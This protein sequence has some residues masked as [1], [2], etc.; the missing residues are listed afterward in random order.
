MIA[1][2]ISSESHENAKKFRVGKRSNL[3]VWL[4]F[5]TSE[6]TA[7]LVNYTCKIFIELTPGLNIVFAQRGCNGIVNTLAKFKLMCS[8]HDLQYYLAKSTVT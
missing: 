7:I 1:L 6:T 5:S 4:L 8:L 2:K 3:Q